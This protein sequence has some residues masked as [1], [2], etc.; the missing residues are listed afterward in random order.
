MAETKTA[1]ANKPAW[2]DL[3]TSDAAGARDFYGKLFGWKIE[4]TSDP[5]YGGYA[6][7]KI[8]GKDVV[9]VLDGLGLSEGKWFIVE[10]KL[11]SDT[12]LSKAQKQVKAHLEKGGSVTI[13][14]T[15]KDKLAELSKTLK[16]ASNKTLDP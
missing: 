6:M 9:T 7:A 2:V 14:A 12:A 1:I 11:H 4:V 5:Q 10:T 13:A 8:N 3:S 15:D 16:G